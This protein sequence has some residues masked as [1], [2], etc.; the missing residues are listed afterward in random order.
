MDSTG[1]G[2]ASLERAYERGSDLWDTKNADFKGKKVEA[3]PVHAMK[4]YRGSRGV[5]PLILNLGAR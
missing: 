4:V 1:S 5:L 2:C 3:I